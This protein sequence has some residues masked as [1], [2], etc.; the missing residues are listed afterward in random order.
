VMSQSECK[1]KPIFSTMQ[2]ILEKSSS[3]KK[4]ISFFVLLDSFSSSFLS[5]L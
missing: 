1:V 3:N 5:R 2:E 4:K